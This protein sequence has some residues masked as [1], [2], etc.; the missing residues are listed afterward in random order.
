MI[1]KELYE[2]FFSTYKRSYNGRVLRPFNWCF[3]PREQDNGYIEYINRKVRPCI[4]ISIDAKYND[5]N[6]TIDIRCYYEYDGHFYDKGKVMFILSDF[7]KNTYNYLTT[8]DKKVNFM[9]DQEIMTF[10]KQF[11]DYIL[12]LQD[13]PILYDDYVKYK[14]HITNKCPELLYNHKSSICSYSV[15]IFPGGGGIV[16]KF[17]YYYYPGK[18]GGY[19]EFMMFRNRELGD[20]FHDIET[21]LYEEIIKRYDMILCDFQSFNIFN[22]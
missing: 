6:N 16:I 20:D 10:I 14:I 21:D 17:D 7:K 15:S 8:D 1:S 5:I 4:D 9:A 19:K 18:V 2:K 3:T 22:L 12:E 13:T 11:D